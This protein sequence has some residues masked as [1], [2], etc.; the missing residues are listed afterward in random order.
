MLILITFSFIFILI[1]IYRDII[2]KFVQD[3][4]S[5]RHRSPKQYIVHNSVRKNVTIQPDPDLNTA[6]YPQTF[7]NV[8][9]Q[10]D[11]QNSQIGNHFTSGVI[12]SKDYI[13]KDLK[14]SFSIKQPASYTPFI[15]DYVHMVNR[16]V[17]KPLPSI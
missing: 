5:H 3:L 11:K 10:N 2:L 15:Q 1:L 9:F 13:H 12:F 17:P 8:H 4:M 14:N 16:P 7:L 6:P